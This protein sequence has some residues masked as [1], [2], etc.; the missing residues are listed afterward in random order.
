MLSGEATDP[1]RLFRV[2]LLSPPWAPFNRPSLQL[3]ALK[4]YLEKEVAGVEVSCHHHY[5]KVAK[6]LGPAA[7][8]GLA[9]SGW[10]G[11]ALYAPLLFPAM[12][13][14]AERLYAGESHR[15]EAG[16]CGP[17][18][19]EGVALVARC[20]DESLASLPLADLELVGFSVCFNQLLPALVTAGKIK[21]L[22][23]ELPVV[24]GG[25]ACGNRQMAAALLAVF[26]QVDHAI[27]GEGE[28]PLAALIGDLRRGGKATRQGLYPQLTG[29]AGEGQSRS[30]LADLDSLPPPDFRDYF[31]ELARVFAGAGFFPELPVEFSRGCWWGKCSFCNLNLQWCGYRRKSAGRML[32]EVRQLAR[33]HGCLDFF[34]TDNVL[35][36]PESRAF[37][38][39]MAAAPDDFRFFAEMRSEQWRDLAPGSRGGLTEIQVGIESLS[40]SLLARM[41]KGSSVIANLA[42]MKHAQACGLQLTG[43]LITEFPGATAAE[44][45]ET[46]EALEYAWPFSPLAPA[47]FFLGR[48]SPM[49]RQ[50]ADF[51]ITARTVHQRARGL[52]PPEVLA[53]L[54]LLVKGFRGDRRHQRRLWR[55]VHLRL[56]QWREFHRRR[57]APAHLSPPLNYRDGGNF[58]LLRQELPD[59]R[60]LRHRL[61][62]LSRRLYLACGEIREIDDLLRDFS[63]IS[64]PALVEFLDDLAGKRL[65]FREGDLVLALAVHQGRK[66]IS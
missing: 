7:Y 62:G 51:A 5:L 50:P 2:A 23:P 3:A 55:P 31:T 9:L 52:Y 49:D 29:Q 46:L 57:P 36:G 24:F 19:S 45:G 13:A 21:E 42:M 63:G 60:V 27:W 44:V 4:A 37:F 65:L 35:P 58:L 47:G 48:G 41:N 17:S 20:L 1:P 53:R 40:A 14:A 11:E 26:P 15:L 10:A 12:A 39:E 33:E 61:S 18:F 59:G 38:R 8:Q 30:Q 66:E 28:M 32:A 64:R 43:N 22:C 54:P 25:S 16:A 56:R 6:D 34:F